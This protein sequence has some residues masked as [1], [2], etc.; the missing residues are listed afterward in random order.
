MKDKM[1][2]AIAKL[3][4]TAI[5][6]PLTYIFFNQYL[7]KSIYFGCSVIYL[8]K[9]QEKE[10]MKIYEESIL[11]KIGLS[12]KFPR[13]ILYARKSA[14]G[15]G[16]MRPSTIVNTLAIKLYIRHQQK[17][18]R[19]ASFININEENS[20][21]DNGINKDPIKTPHNKRFWEYTWSDEITE[22]LQKRDLEVINQD[23]IKNQ[24]MSNK[25][26]I[27][28]AVEFVKLKQ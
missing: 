17:K 25:T 28:Y 3:Q 20:F 2:C 1:R 13:Q 10:L 27:D 18:S 22:Y 23:E 16:I 11:K 26:I 19:L 6:L 4:N 5:D 14:L 7:I 24:V 12:A 15:V 9:T 21:I 8:N